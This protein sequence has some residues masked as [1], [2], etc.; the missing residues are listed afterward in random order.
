MEYLSNTTLIKA[1]INNIR[2]LLVHRVLELLHREIDRGLENE[3]WD[4]LSCEWYLN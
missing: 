1:H 2:Y 3:V 4:S